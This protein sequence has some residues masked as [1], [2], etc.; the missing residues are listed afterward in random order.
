MQNSCRKTKSR[1]LLLIG[2]KLLLGTPIRLLIRFFIR[3]LDWY[4]IRQII[5]YVWS[6]LR[7]YLG[8]QWTKFRKTSFISSFKCWA[9]WTARVVISLGSVWGWEGTSCW[10]KARAPWDDHW[11]YVMGSDWLSSGTGYRTQRHWVTG[12]WQ[13]QKIS[14]TSM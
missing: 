13:N 8:S 7:S 6:K 10:S 4:D 1:D 5:F 14:K 3:N 9:A 11:P 12:V 2:K